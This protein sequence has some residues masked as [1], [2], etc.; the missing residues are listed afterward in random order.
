LDL[1]MVR[2][3]IGMWEG[4]VISFHKVHLLLFEVAFVLVNLS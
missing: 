1:L 3:W 2:Y 4:V